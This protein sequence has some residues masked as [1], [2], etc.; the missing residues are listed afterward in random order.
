MIGEFKMFLEENAKSSIVAQI[1]S[2][3]DFQKSSFELKLLASFLFDCAKFFARRD[4]SNKDTIFNILF[5]TLWEHFKNFEPIHLSGIRI[6]EGQSQRG[7]KAYVRAK[8][9]RGSLTCKK[10]G[11]NDAYID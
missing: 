5:L 2:G 11:K 9:Q 7:F 4:V 6:Q 3:T 1:H 10:G 8:L